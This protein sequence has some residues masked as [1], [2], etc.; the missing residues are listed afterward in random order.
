MS[1]ALAVVVGIDHYPDAA[2]GAL[3][4]AVNDAEEFCTWLQ[5][6]A[7]GGLIATNQAKTTEIHKIVSV[8]DGSGP[9]DA[10]PMTSD[11]EVALEYVREKAEYRLS[12]W[13]Q[14]QGA[15]YRRLYLF[16]AG[17]GIGPDVEQAA[18]LMANA[19]QGRFGHYVQGRPFA[20][21]FRQRA[22]FD[23]VL[24][25][26]DCCRD[27]YPFIA[28]PPLKWD[29]PQ[30]S[31]RA[32]N[33]CYA[34]A[35]KWSKKSRE[36]MLGGKQRGFFS[37]ALLEG[38]KGSAADANGAVAA[39][40]LESYVTARIPKLV[41]KGEVQN[42]EFTYPNKTPMLIADYGPAA[43]A[44][45]LTPVQITVTAPEQASVLRI[46]DSEFEPASLVQEARPSAGVWIFRLP[47]GVYQVRNDAGRTKTFEVVGP[48]TVDV[49]F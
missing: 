32:V 28:P 8:A 37:A 23:E 21:Y 19:G 5:T 42:P 44:M 22:S 31:G 12:D 27:S 47:F 16:F 38:L 24:L 20:N 39:D 46:V 43:A 29:P 11:I 13:E 7:A 17:H 49:T 2:L 30:P 9:L 35:T 14:G 15:P 3:Q 10:R 18:L 1:D 40:A 33:H 41:R 34:F 26:M 4:G 6:P 36:T 25:F 48:E 45:L